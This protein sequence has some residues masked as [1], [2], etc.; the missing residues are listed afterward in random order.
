MEGPTQPMDE[1]ITPFNPWLEIWIR[2]R[3]TIR[4]IV[5]SNP[6]RSVLLLAI[7]GGLVSFFA[8]TIRY[9]ENA[10]I[11]LGVVIVAL[12]STLGPLFG[13]LRLYIGGA[14]LR[15]T[16]SWFGGKADSS[17]VRA[18]IAWASLPE[19]ALSLMVLI[20][21]VVLQVILVPNANSQSLRP[22]LFILIILFLLMVIVLTIWHEILVIK[23]LAEVHG[24]SAWRSL[25]AIYLPSLVLV[26]NLYLIFGAAIF[27]R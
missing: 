24:Y 10:S 4:R 14:W 1:Q 16:G 23:T 6:T 18:A 11:L 19:L 13:V 9:L 25:A 22:V 27:N 7:L 17:Q 5:D 12:I 3:K 2:P 21:V 8:G 15:W 20:F 26:T